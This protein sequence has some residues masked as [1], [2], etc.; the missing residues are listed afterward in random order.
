[1]FFVPGR[2]GPGNFRPEDIDQL[3]RKLMGMQFRF[4]IYVVPSPVSP[5]QVSLLPGLRSIR[6]PSL[7]P[8]P[9]PPAS[10]P[11]PTLTPLPPPW[12]RVAKPLLKPL[13][14]A[15]ILSPPPPLIRHPL[16]PTEPPRP[17][18]KRLPT[19]PS[20]PPEPPLPP[21]DPFFRRLCVI[22]VLSGLPICLFAPPAGAL[23]MVGFGFWL[24]VLTATER[25]RRET[26][27]QNRKA[28]YKRT[29]QLIDEEYADLCRPIEEVNTRLTEV[30]AAS[31]SAA[32]KEHE[33]HCR[34]VDEENIR[35]LSAYDFVKSELLNEHEMACRQVELENRKVLD[36]W[37]KENA[38]R[39]AVYDSSRRQVDCA[40]QAL[41]DAWKALQSSRRMS[42][43]Q[44]CR[45]IDEKNRR[46]IAAWEAA[47]SPWVVERKRWH[48]LA[49]T[50]DAEIKRLE[51][52]IHAQ[53]TATEA[54][55]KQ[56]KAEAGKLEEAYK[57]ARGDYERD[58]QQAEHDSKRIQLE[59]YLDKKLIRQAR[60]K[61]ITYDRILSLES[62]GIETAKDVPLLNNQKVPGIG[63]VLTGRLFE[64][65]LSLEASFR[66]QKGLPDSVKSR[67]AARYAPVMRP[68]GQSIQEVISDLTA[69]VRLHDAREAELTRDIAAAVQ[70]LATAEA[71]TKI[72]K[73]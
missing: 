39:Q 70:N 40:N 6:K 65:R 58:L 69:I 55:F 42:H 13:P 29:C 12:T 45:E 38:A 15:P 14:P 16:P 59:D 41:I 43:E 72:L 3:L 37:E 73:L 68:L 9:T 23:I 25:G 1:M 19:R 63:P 36:A 54:K 67:I 22:G 24:M 34:A 60:L 32:L 20:Y 8:H 50:A 28:E 44:A 35:R 10:V 47:N 56:R 48:D 53:R 33:K 17:R 49:T 26:E 27:R 4:T 61:G 46:T 64:W 21:P 31:Y 30:W 52:E 62:F 11:K 5:I 2:G 71:Y 7:L 57:R 51:S 18:L 66:P